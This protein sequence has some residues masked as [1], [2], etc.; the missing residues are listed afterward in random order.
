[1]KLQ[2]CAFALGVFVL[3]GA[4]VALAGNADVRAQEGPDICDCVPRPIDLWAMSNGG[5][6]SLWTIDVAGNTTTLVGILRDPILHDVGVGWSTVAETPDGTLYFLRRYTTN[7]HVFSLDSAHIQIDS[8]GV[9]TNLVSVGATGLSGNLDGLTAGPDGNLYF[10]AYEN[11]SFNTGAPRNGL[12]RFRPPPPNTCPICTLQ[13]QPPGTAVTELVG[14]F[15]G[16]TVG[17]DYFY[18]DLTFDPF[19]GDLIGTG[20]DE[21]AGSYRGGWT[22][23]PR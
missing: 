10:T 19:S 14:T 13:G 17:K 6:G 2:R 12:F 23:L 9:I 1:M 21:M 4:G 5:D 7:V 22:A 18:T 16:N 3:S 11:E 15:R 8:T 20:R